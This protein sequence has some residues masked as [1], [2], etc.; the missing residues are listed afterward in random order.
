MKGG[1]ERQQLFLGSPG[2]VAHV[3]VSHGSRTPFLCTRLKSIISVS[4]LFSSLA[5]AYVSKQQSHRTMMKGFS[6]FLISHCFWFCM[7]IKKK[8][9]PVSL[10]VM[11]LPFIFPEKSFGARRLCFHN[12]GDITEFSLV[13]LWSISF[14]LDDFYK[15]THMIIVTEQYRHVKWIWME[16]LDILFLNELA[17]FEVVFYCSPLYLGIFDQ[18]FMTF[19]IFSSGELWDYYEILILYMSHWS[20]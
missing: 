11:Q 19:I 7:R 9:F 6:G 2:L 1:S 17:I 14:V 18:I 16:S 4:A 8:N 15:L 20:K 13:F 12:F 3:C 5:Q 10:S